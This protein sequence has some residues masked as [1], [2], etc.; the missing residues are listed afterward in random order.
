MQKRMGAYNLMQF[1]EAIEGGAMAV[2][3]RYEGW[4]PQEVQILTSKARSDARRP[5]VH[6][7]FDL[8]AVWGQ[9]PENI[10]ICRKF[11]SNLL[12]FGLVG[13]LIE[14]YENVNFTA[15]PYMEVQ[16]RYFLPG[17]AH[18]QCETEGVRVESTKAREEG[19]GVLCAGRAA[20]A[21][22]TRDF[23]CLAFIDD[24]CPPV[25]TASPAGY[26]DGV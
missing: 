9:K 23:V 24:K 5:D 14:L 8:Y 11:E 25:R 18:I 22:H 6:V 15:V 7:L 21:A 4:A 16:A 26:M 2:M 13:G 20:V 10:P 19:R 12:L 1:V 3:T 17:Y